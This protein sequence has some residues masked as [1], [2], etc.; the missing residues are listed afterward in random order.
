MLMAGT[1]D[2]SW[3]KLILRSKFNELQESY[4][5]PQHPTCILH[6]FFQKQLLKNAFIFQYIFVIL[7]KQHLGVL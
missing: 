4:P 3:Q 2:V 6:S 5:Y 1:F 7:S